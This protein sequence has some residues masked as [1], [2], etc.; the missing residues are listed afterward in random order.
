MD[1]HTHIIPS[2]RDQWPVVTTAITG[3]LGSGKSTV[4]AMLESMG[5]PT[6]DCDDLALRA[7]APATPGLAII[8]ETFG[9][10]VLKPDG[11]LD[12]SRMLNLILHDQDARNKLEAILHP[13]VFKEMEKKLRRLA[14]QR[15]HAAIVEVPLL[16]E[17][18]WH[19]LFDLNCMVTAPESVCISRIMARNN[20]DQDTARRWLDL[21]M[22]RELKEQLADF[23]IRNDGER[24]DLEAQVDELY[25]T[26]EE[27]AH[28]RR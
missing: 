12:R 7:T 17:A 8:K 24:E 13:L 21:Q 26:I 14:K 27:M 20:V 6:L 22:A 2:H 3:M 1:Q 18:G 11:S 9:P 4:V 19:T 5:I 28:N 23:V 25:K 10:E 16:F 15:H